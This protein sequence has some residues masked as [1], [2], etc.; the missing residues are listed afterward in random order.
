MKSAA[1]HNNRLARFYHLGMKGMVLLGAFFCTTGA[2]YANPALDHV[3]AGDVSIQQASGSTVVNQNSQKA[4]INWQSFN[5][6]QSES[7]HFQQPAGGV[8]LNRING[9]QG[10]SSIYGRLTATGQIILMNPAGIYFGPT[11]YVNVGGMIATTGNMTDA[12]FLQGNYRFSSVPSYSGS[13]INDGQIISHG[14]IALV[15]P[16]V[17]NNGLIQANM[18]NVILASGNAFTIDLTGDQLVN[19]TIDERPSGTQTGITNMGAIVANGG[20]ILVT[21]Q[22][23]QG[24]L[25]NVINMQGTVQ[26]QSV[27]Q[28][29]G[30][31]V[32]SSDPNAGNVYVAATLDASGIIGG[33]VQ[34]TGYNILLD[35]PTVIDVRGEQGGGNI[36]IGGNANAVVMAPQASLFADAITSGNGGNVTLFA[37]HVIKAYGSISAR[38]GAEGGDGGFIETSSHDFMD[39]SAIAVD[40]RAP[41]G[42]TGTW[43]IDPWNVT[44]STAATS[45]GAFSGASPNVFTPTATA[46]TVNT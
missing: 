31:I 21:A 10:P 20:K 4:I 35:S 23:A 18:G 17:V 36:T 39:L 7:T 24:V 45:A 19:F 41:L 27:S 6:G 38:G 2:L 37:D 3:A 40:L 29:N 25:D 5:I 13:I 28:Q 32:L 12:D 34:I 11:A 42:Q 16:Q 43:L 14:L 22:A 1:R 30:E 46:A 15:A 26:A 9:A 44:I 8:A 33:K